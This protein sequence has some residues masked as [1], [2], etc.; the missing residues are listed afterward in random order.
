LYVEIF[1]AILGIKKSALWAESLFGLFL[2][3]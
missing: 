2:K 1:L 3:T